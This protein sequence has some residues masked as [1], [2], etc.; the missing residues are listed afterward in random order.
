[1]TR[2]EIIQRF[3]LSREI[4]KAG[5]KL[6][7]SG[8]SRFMAKCLFHED[9]TA[10]MSVDDS[11]GLFN[12]FG[13]KAAGSVI[14]FW[15]RQR[16]CQPADILREM[17]NG[18]KNGGSAAPTR[19]PKAPP[20]NSASPPAEKTIEW[21]YSYENQFGWEVYQVVRYKPKTFRQRHQDENDN[22]VWSMEG[23]TRVLYHLPQ[24]MGAERVWICE[25]EKDAETLTALG[26][27][28]T[29]NV[30]GAGK[31]LDA[32][33]ETLAGKEI[34]LCG[35]ND[36]AGEEHV[37]LV[38][39]S[40]AG[41][42][43]NTRQINLPKEF[44]DASD[45]AASFATPAEARAALESL[46]DA[47]PVLV[48]GYNIPLFSMP[49]MEVRFS[50]YVRELKTSEFDLGRWLPSLGRYVRGLIPGELV[51]I[52]AD[53]GV[54]KTIALGNIAIAARPL[55]TVMFELELPEELLY[56]RFLAAQMRWDYATILQNYLATDNLLGADGLE[57][58]DHL[59]CCTE[60]RLTLEDI[61]RHIN[62]AELK[63]GRRPKVVLID[64]VQLMQG[65]S[66]DRRSRFSDVAEGL[67]VMAKATKTIVVI[68]SQVARKEDDEVEIF[69]H[70]PK[71]SGSIE[72]SSGLVL[73]IWRDKVNSQRLYVK[74]LKNT[75]GRSGP[76]IPCGF[77][78]TSSDEWTPRIIELVDDPA[79][80][81]PQQQFP[82]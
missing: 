20:S 48:K 29:C 79:P 22:W 59:H 26:F 27:V 19:L 15:A 38:F 42:V 33:T 57:A 13:C 49:E 71:E 18:N 73:G 25:G 62:R 21:I 34:V 76:V 35:D 31:W 36:K 40:I 2:D 1:M 70:D 61:E 52:V 32:Y 44:K 5:G 10:S 8:P 24:V 46:R 75:K 60:S 45:Y 7:A 47:A 72:N 55:P 50:K 67:K 63:T 64:Y 14:D 82:D 23:V 12:C 41:K 56:E 39:E 68:A 11:K 80:P 54:G 30:G 77:R 58:L 37:A 17:G 6:T 9:G 43:K 78:Y 16:N 81:D 4:E 28:A 74:I 69:L 65:K 3:P 53:T 66:S 51:T